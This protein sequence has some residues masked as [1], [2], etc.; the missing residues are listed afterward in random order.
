MIITCGTIANPDYVPETWHTYL[1]LLL[2][3]VINGLLTMQSTR[4]IGQ[5]NKVGTILN[6]AVVLIFVIWFPVGSINTPKTN[7]NRVVWTSFENGTDW[8]IG[9]ATIMGLFAFLPLLPSG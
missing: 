8:P 9:W 3:L 5:L 6:M 7:S 2:I 4:F 1:V